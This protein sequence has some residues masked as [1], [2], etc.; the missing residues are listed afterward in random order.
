AE[1]VREGDEV[2]PVGEVPKATAIA[3]ARSDRRRAQGASVITT[4]E[5][6]D[7][8]FAGSIAHDLERVFDRLRATDV[9][10]RASFQAEFGLVQS[11]D[12]GRQLYLFSM[13]ILTGELRQFV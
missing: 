3:I 5:C 10:M 13:Q 2:R 6:K 1:A 4:H 11:C 12:G 9:E 8:V 7:Q